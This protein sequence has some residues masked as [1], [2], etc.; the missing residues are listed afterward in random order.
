ML[1]KDAIQPISPRKNQY[2]SNLFLLSKRDGGN[3]PVINWEHLNSFIPYQ[4]FKMEGM[5]L[6]QNMLQKGD[7]MCKVDLKVNCFC[8]SLKKES[9][10][11]VR[12]QW[13]ETL[14][15][16][17]FLCFGLD[18]ARLIFTKIL[19]VPNSPLRRIQIRVII[20]LDEMLLMS[21][22]LEVLLMRR[23]TIIFLL[24]QLGFVISLK[25]VCLS[26]SPTNR[27]FRLG[28]RFCR[29]ETISSSKKGGGDCLD[30]PKCNGRQF[31]LKGFDC[32]SYSGN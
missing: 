16:F 9:R 2:L 23:D 10:K 4:H 18:P 27:I 8:V 15:K 29:N 26:A 3:R 13:Q 28:E 30:V 20:Y 19:K 25:K 5:N 6:L 22:T 31:D 11:Y 14:Y 21:Q 1:L 32:G 12:F 7:Y 17:L 24:T